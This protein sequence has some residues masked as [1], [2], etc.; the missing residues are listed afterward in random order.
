MPTTLTEQLYPFEFL[1]GDGDNGR[2]SYDTYQ[3]L[4]GT[5]GLAD[6]TTKN[7]LPAGSVISLITSG[8]Y[9]GQITQFLHANLGNSDG[10]QTPFGILAKAYDASTAAVPNC[11][12]LVRNATVNDALLTWD[13]NLTTTSITGEKPTAQRT[14]DTNRKIVCR[15]GGISG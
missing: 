8:T 7:N 14:L 13:S 10:T 2:N 1:T 12:V 9:K 3:L 4:I 15:T 6:S 11:L 5:N